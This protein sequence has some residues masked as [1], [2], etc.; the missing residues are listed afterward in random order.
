MAAVAAQLGW[1]FMPWQTLVVYEALRHQGGRLTYRDVA[2]STPRQSGKSTL[3]LALLLHRLMSAPAQRVVY[4][5]QSRL[6]ARVKLIDDWWPRIERS[7]LGALFTLRT[8]NG[9]ESLRCSNGSQMTLLS[10]ESS[11]GH[12]S[13]IDMAVLDECWSL[14]AESEQAVKPAAAT[15]ANAQIWL[16]STAGT[17]KSVWW[18]SKVDAG[19]TEAELG[20]ASGMLYFEWSA[21]DGVDLADPEMWQTW[22]PAL[23]RTIEPSVLA[24]DLASMDPNE[25]S[26]AYGNVWPSDGGGWRVISQEAWDAAAWPEGT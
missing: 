9:A 13:S 14:S 16:L 6:A 25:W 5:A 23:H 10:T 22:H 7:P 2:V 1:E 11:A 21:A 15:R 17:E 26:R 24:A 8:A 18:R 12:G 3:V 20:S 4:A 19:R